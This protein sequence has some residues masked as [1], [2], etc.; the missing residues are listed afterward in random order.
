AERGAIAIGAGM[1]PAGGPAAYGMAIAA[2]VMV[3]A[4]GTAMSQP[5]GISTG[6]MTRCFSPPSATTRLSTAIQ[7]V[8]RHRTPKRSEVSVMV[9]S[10]SSLGVLAYRS[11]RSEEH[12]SELQSRENLVCRLL[13]EKKK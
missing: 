4:A 10:S 13:L 5:S 9:R 3:G 6:W 11:S 7:A 1:A 8:K 12:T 2:I